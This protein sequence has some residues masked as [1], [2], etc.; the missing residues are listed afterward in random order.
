M[1]EYA[2]NSPDR[3]VNLTKRGEVEK[4]M[5]AL[6]RSID[7]FLNRWESVMLDVLLKQYRKPLEPPQ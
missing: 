7:Q 6:K 4:Q 5:A 3:R 2:G 1:F